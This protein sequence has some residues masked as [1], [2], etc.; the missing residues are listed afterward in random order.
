[1]RTIRINLPFAQSTGI[2]ERHFSLFEWAKT[3]V[4][5]A[6]VNVIKE[7]HYEESSSMLV[8]NTYNLDDEYADTD[9]SAA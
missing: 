1:M 3:L 4:D 5:S 9:F 6:F 7:E 2:A 8:E